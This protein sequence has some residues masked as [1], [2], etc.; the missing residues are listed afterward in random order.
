MVNP[1]SIIK[2]CP[3]IQRAASLNRYTQAKD[4][5]LGSPS[6]NGNPPMRLLYS[7][8]DNVE[9][10]FCIIGVRIVPGEM[11]FTLTFRLASSAA[12]TLEALTNAPFDALYAAVPT[13]AIVA[14]MEQMNIIPPP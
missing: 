5:S 4:T 6:P 13:R 14:V 1:P 3:V 12:R 2:F 10:Y 8:S 7:S 11:Q 9:R